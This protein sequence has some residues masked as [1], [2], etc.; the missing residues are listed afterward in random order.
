MRKYLWRDDT[1]SDVT[2]MGNANGRS[3][4][5]ARGA[6]TTAGLVLAA[7]AM[8]VG[9]AV[10]ASLVVTDTQDVRLRV[11]KSE[12]AEG[13]DSGWHSHPGPVIVQVEEGQFKIYQGGC[14][15]RVVHAGETLIEVPLVPV[16]AI[17]QGHIKWTTSQ[18]LPVGF[19][20]QEPAA[21]PCQ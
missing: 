21:A 3:R 7:L 20:A 10:G 11:V 9:I 4:P 13:F 18:I 14:E 19:D 16:R 15:P 1:A 17:A 6:V 12:F 8:A 5:A 2:L